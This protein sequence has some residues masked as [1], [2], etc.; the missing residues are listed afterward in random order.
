MATF[1]FRTAAAA[2]R[3]CRTAWD[4]RCIESSLR[5]RI[6]AE[7]AETVGACPYCLHLRS[8]AS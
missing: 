7:E 5:N 8:Q 3:E 4:R 2:K 6:A 1:H